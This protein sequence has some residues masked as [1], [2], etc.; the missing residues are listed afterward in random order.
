V[1][2]SAQFTVGTAASMIVG[3]PAGVTVPGP[4]GW[5]YITNGSGGI[6]YLGSPGVSSSNGAAVAASA[7]QSGWLFQ[8][9]AIWACTSTG[10]STVGV[11]VTGA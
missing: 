2:G 6:I 7:T 4:V 8:G 3:A 11:L 10:T 5:F 1:A 9:D